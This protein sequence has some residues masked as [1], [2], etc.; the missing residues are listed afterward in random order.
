MMAREPESAVA[1]D[2]L[3]AG[4]VSFGWP[5]LLQTKLALPPH[6]SFLVSRRRLTSALDNRPDARLILIAAPAGFGKTTLAIEWLSG[7][8]P[9]TVAWLGLDAA[10]NDTN[11][12]WRYVFDA[13]RRARPNFGSW[14]A[15]LAPGTLPPWDA[16]VTS[17]L[18]ELDTLP[19]P[20]I[21]T[22][23]DYHIIHEPAIH[24][25]INY[26][27]QRA[28]QNL[29]LVITSRA[30]PPL[31]LARLQ[32]QDGLVEIRAADLR[33]TRDEIETYLNR[34]M[35]L[36][37]SPD[38]IDALQQRTEGW[39]AGVHL[40]ARSLAHHLPAERADFVRTFSGTHRYVLNYLM[41]EVLHHQP[42]DMRE[43]LLHTSVL[44]RLA[45]PL[46]EAVTGRPDSQALLARAAHEGLFITPL[47]RDGRWYHFHPLF[48]EALELQ[49]RENDPSLLAEL[50]RRASG[51]CVRNGHVE[52]A[53]NHALSS[54]EFDRAVELIEDVAEKT[55][56]HGGLPTLQGWLDAL[57]KETVARRFP[58]RL[59]YTWALFLNDRWD[60]AT[61]H[62]RESRPLLNDTTTPEGR[63][64]LGMWA[65]I[66]GAMMAHKDEPEATLRL[67]A[68]AFELLAP[69]TVTWRAIPM[70][71][72]GLAYMTRGKVDEAARSFSQAAD[73]TV[74]HG[75]EYLAFASLWHWSEALIAGGH[76]HRA[77]AVF[78]QL[79]QMETTPGGKAMR[80]AAYADIGL[81]LLACERN[82]LLMAES[83]LNGGLERIWPGGQPRVMIQARLALARVASALGDSRAARR[84]LLASLDV[85]RQ[86]RLPALDRPIEAY[87]TLLAVRS[88]EWSVVELWE[89][90]LQAAV[91]EHPPA[92]RETEE[93][94]RGQIAIHRREFATAER[95]LE[96]LFAAAEAEG[97]HGSA[98]A[99]LPYLALALAG[100]GK[101]KPAEDVL[102]R[103]IAR[104]ERE[105][106][107][108]VFLDAGPRL[109]ELLSRPAVRQSSP[110]YVG[111]L[112]HAAAAE[113]SD[114]VSA[115]R[116]GETSYFEPLTPREL[117]ILDLIA[118]GASNQ[119]IAEQLYL[120]VGTVKGHVNHTFSKLDVHNRTSAVARA[121]E[122]GILVS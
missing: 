8:D 57:P 31:A 103:A 91:D 64:L 115:A 75:N 95:I 52:R 56:S 33:F 19:Q 11:R 81:G 77:A 38:H 92:L 72:V 99:I 20:I 87:L 79:Q 68:E 67:T 82:E 49:L 37:L 5:A 105:G 13:I 2:G 102:L 21:L 109:V 100:Q 112:L 63:H 18:N 71:N 65:A 39:P 51:W 32:V 101:L 27:L 85:V 45:A 28:P 54:G 59:Y 55:W 34:M 93:W 120:S 36:D 22:L 9:S 53:I 83:L 35:G 97:R 50:H 17:L 98:M 76:L 23:D 46:C 15:R 16:V 111:Q 74:A 44:Q 78:D 110:R 117:D 6:R 41:E 14:M 96:P 10:D 86:Y 118:K 121:R 107:V 12:F 42:P 94:V 58:L 60:E 106:H 30:D 113:G 40:L 90:R 48:S 70:I 89:S 25:S 119:D 43:F 88:G 47:D 7:R 3:P 24:Q 4:A 80:L 73:L 26:L 84:H 116:P 69:D 114:D 29:R 108:R 66:G 61:T 1:S 122:L 104:G 62:W